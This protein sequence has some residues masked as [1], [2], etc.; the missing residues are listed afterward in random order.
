MRVRPAAA[1]VPTSIGAPANC[2]CTCSPGRAHVTGLLDESMGISVE[3]SVNELDKLT[4]SLKTTRTV[5][6]SARP[7]RHYAGRMYRPSR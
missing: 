3:T 4:L 6:V 5:D 2:K 7:W 1:T